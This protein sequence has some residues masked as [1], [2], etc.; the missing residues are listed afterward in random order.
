MFLWEYLGGV[1]R[2]KHDDIDYAERF[3]WLR[4]LPALVIDEL[5]VE[6]SSE[7]VFRTRRSLLDWRYRA[8]L[9][10]RSITVLASNDAP[11]AW[12]DSAIA[13]RALDGRF[14]AVDTGKTS[15][16]RIKRA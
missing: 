3:K 4:D 12:Q 14:V 6:K 2:G 10:G 11:E 15:Y 1:E 16:R 13:D 9:D 8:A 7:F 5:N